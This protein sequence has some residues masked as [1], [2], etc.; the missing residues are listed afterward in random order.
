M[1]GYDPK[2]SEPLAVVA[3]RKGEEITV[4]IDGL[5]IGIWRSVLPDDE[6]QPVVQI[7]GSGMVRVN[8]NDGPVW[9]AD[10]QTHDHKVCRCVEEFEDRDRG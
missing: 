7:D 6:G 2:G 1:S 3:E 9:N 4:S 8:I 5:E 10:P